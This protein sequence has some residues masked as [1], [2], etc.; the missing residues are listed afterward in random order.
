[1]SRRRSGVLAVSGLLVMGSGLHGQGAPTPK[2][3]PFRTLVPS[4]AAN[5]ANHGSCV[6]IGHGLIAVGATGD[7]DSSGDHNGLVR[8]WLQQESVPGGSTPFLLELPVEQA[9]DGGTDNPDSNQAPAFGASIAISE[10]LIAVGAPWFDTEDMVDVGAVLVYRRLPN[11]FEHVAT[12]TADR[13]VI[14]GGFGVSVQF[15]GEGGL[16][17]GAPWSNAGIVERHVPLASGDWVYEATFS[18]ASGVAGDDFG[19]SLAWFEPRGLLVIAAAGADEVFLQELTGDSGLP[20]PPLTTL[21]VPP[22][23]GDFASSIAADASRIAVGVPDGASG[24]K[25]ILYASAGFSWQIDTV[26]GAPEG[27]DDFGVDTALDGRDLLVAAD[28]SST[29]HEVHVFTVESDSPVVHRLD[30]RGDG[31]GAWRSLAVASGVGYTGDANAGQFGLAYLTLLDRDCDANGVSDLDQIAANPDLDCNGNDIFDACEIL[32]GSVTDCDGDG[33]IDDCSLN[34]N[35]CN[36]NGIDDRLEGPEF[37]FKNPQIPVDLIV[38]ADPSGSSD[39]KMP[40]LCTEVFRTAADRLSEDFDLRSAWVSMVVESPAGCNDCP[41]CHDWTIPLGTPVP[42]CDGAPA[43]SID[44]NTEGP[45][46]E[47]GDGTAVMTRPYSSDL[48]GQFPEWSERDAVLILV[49]ISDEGPQDGGGNSA[50]AC[51]CDDQASAWNLIRQAWIENVQVI[52]M[53]TEG[54]PDCVYDPNDPSSLMR[55]VAEETGGSVLDA[56]DWSPGDGSTGQL[57]ND[58]EAAIRDAIQNAPRIKRLVADFN[59][60]GIVDVNDLLALIGVYGLMDGDEEWSERYDLDG[61]GFIGV[62]D[63]LAVLEAYGESCDGKLSRTIM[64][65][66]DR[67]PLASSSG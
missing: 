42:V 66:S 12:L 5:G 19:S 30:I 40:D 67:R 15:D 59:G 49:T 53:P 25:V 17:I 11:A 14:D 34:G 3:E 2:Q 33:V 43:R 46:E 21:P 54:T 65:G 27:V 56:R 20:V 16:C 61:D 8:V 26:I 18:S 44:N 38:V 47:W 36:A 63:L 29:Q 51:D 28:G 6:A 45:G 13:K 41:E 1:M 37:C 60:N 35:D 9:N 24:G 31:S 23:G 62:N 4:D 50:D 10:G 39:G 7:E 52:T 48:L 55:V 32:D 58:F 57:S 22:G 64:N